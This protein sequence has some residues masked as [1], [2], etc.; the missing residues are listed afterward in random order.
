MN[1]N[2]ITTALNLSSAQQHYTCSA[3]IP[4][5]RV[6]TRFHNIGSRETPRFA[7]RRESLVSP[8]CRRQLTPA[9]EPHESAAMTLGEAQ[10]PRVR[11]ILNHPRIGTGS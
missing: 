9:Q 3:T 7:S 1:S 10:T 8:N 4:M 2:N 11:E 5:R 6:P